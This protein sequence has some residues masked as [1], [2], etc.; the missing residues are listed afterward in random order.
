MRLLGDP[1]DSRLDIVG[2]PEAGSLYLFAGSTAKCSERDLPA[3]RAHAR[4]IGE[5]AKRDARGRMELGKDCT[6]LAAHQNKPTA[7]GAG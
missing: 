6:H 1:I 5:L 2:W 4:R 7:N 3:A